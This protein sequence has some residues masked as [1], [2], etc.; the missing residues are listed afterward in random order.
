MTNC[1]LLSEGFMSQIIIIMNFVVVLRVGIEGLSV[2]AL[3]EPS[4]DRFQ[5]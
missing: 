1:Y 2:Q 4:Y 3:S 5:S